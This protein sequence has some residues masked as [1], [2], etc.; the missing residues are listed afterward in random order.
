MLSLLYLGKGL[1][2][3]PRRGLHEA[4]P[5]TSTCSCEH[6]CDFL[7]C[8]HRVQVVGRWGDG[9]MREHLIERGWDYV[10]EVMVVF[11]LSAM[12]RGEGNSSPLFKIR[13]MGWIQTVD[14]L[15]LAFSYLEDRENPQTLIK[16]RG[17][18]GK[19]WQAFSRRDDLIMRVERG[20]QYEMNLVPICLVSQG[21]SY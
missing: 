21:G 16:E 5:F 18:V 17:L 3:P 4:G 13:N 11:L 9:V 7:S 2:I 20:C 8:Y 14:F 19:R 1:Q 10:L 15:C 6:L 12:W